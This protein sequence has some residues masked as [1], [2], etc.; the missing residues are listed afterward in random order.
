ML[1]DLLPSMLSAAKAGQYAAHSSLSDGEA[2]VSSSEIRLDVNLGFLL[3]PLKEELVDHVERDL[4][5]VLTRG[6]KGSGKRANQK[7]SATKL[8]A[9]TSMCLRKARRLSAKP[10]CECAE[11]RL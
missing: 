8:T 1:F 10:C 5:S 2:H 3:N 11:Q 9:A 6:S 7:D 4:D